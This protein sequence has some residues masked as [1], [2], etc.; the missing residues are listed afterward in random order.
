MASH[1]LID[2]KR[3]PIILV[4]VILSAIIAIV[5]VVGYFIPEF[6][7][8]TRTESDQYNITNPLLQHKQTVSQFL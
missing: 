4:L 8:R 1:K 5:S 2:H 6:A 7:H 3:E